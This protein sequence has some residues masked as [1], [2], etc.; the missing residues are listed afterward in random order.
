MQLH[1]SPGQALAGSAALSWPPQ[2]P[3]LLPGAVLAVDRELKQPEGDEIEEHD[4]EH[5]G[6]GA[7]WEFSLTT[8]GC[9]DSPDI[10]AFDLALDPPLGATVAVHAIK[11]PLKTK[12]I[13]AQL[14]AWL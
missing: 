3:S 6:D 13:E 10:V 1:V 11:E 5:S 4:G 12:A 7:E 2:L 14:K 8:A 9:D